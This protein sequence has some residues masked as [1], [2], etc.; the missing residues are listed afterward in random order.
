M[1]NVIGIS[2]SSN[3]PLVNSF[4]GPYGALASAFVT[5]LSADGSTVLYGTHYGG[6]G[7]T[8]GHAIALGPAGNIFIAGVTAATNLPAVNSYQPMHRGGVYDMWVA[9]F[10]LSGTTLDYS[11]YPEAPTTTSP[12]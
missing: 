11:T 3:L 7:Y 8:E 4:H 9:K 2:D 12:R 10:S 5:K 1:S 6:T